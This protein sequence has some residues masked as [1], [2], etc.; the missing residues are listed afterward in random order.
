MQKQRLN[1]PVYLWIFDI[2]YPIK[3][4]TNVFNLNIAFGGYIKEKVGILAGVSYYSNT[5]SY[6]ESPGGYTLLDLGAEYNSSG[7]FYSSSAP[8]SMGG[9]NALLT[10]AVDEKLVVRLD[11]G[12]YGGDIVH[13]KT[14]VPEGYD[15]TAFGKKLE[16]SGVWQI[17]DMFGVALK[18]S[19]WNIKTKYEAE[20][21]YNQTTGSGTVEQTTDITLFP[22]RQVKSGT[23]T[24]TIMIPLGSAE[25]GGGGVINLAD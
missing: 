16:L 13:K 7:N 3:S 8:V 24:M 15:G 4:Y 17:S 1:R 19:R 25:G 5:K 12:F 20:V 2:M 22:E 23:F 21:T 10:Y 18:Y 9:V 11:Y 14:T 6:T